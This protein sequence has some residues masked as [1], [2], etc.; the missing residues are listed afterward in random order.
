[1]GSRAFARD[2]LGWCQ[3]DRE[4]TATILSRPLI[5]RNA[6]GGLSGNQDPASDALSTCFCE[7]LRFPSPR[8]GTPGA[9][10]IGWGGKGV[11]LAHREAAY[12]EM[13]GTHERAA[14]SS[15]GSAEEVA[16][17]ART[18]VWSGR[19]GNKRAPRRAVCHLTLNLFS[20]VEACSKGLPRR[21]AIAF[22]L[23]TQPPI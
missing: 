2:S 7:S 23:K 1:M 13:R 10:F 9:G 19:D 4:F 22:P 12:E 18:L 15:V 6:V 17:R 21:T 20:Q 16:Q 14:Q 11:A 3:S 8:P 5:T